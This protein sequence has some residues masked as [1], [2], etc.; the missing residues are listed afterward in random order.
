MNIETRTTETV[1]ITEQQVCEWMSAR[2]LAFRAAGL[3]VHAM[4]LNAILYFP[5]RETAPQTNW[6]LHACGECVGSEPSSQAAFDLLR[7][8]LN[9]DPKSKAREKRQNAEWLLKEAEELEAIV[10]ALAIQQT[11]T[12]I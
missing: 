11:Q 4:S 10:P 9:G 12:A 5:E 6:N 7:E 8:T 1:Q 2:L 3:P